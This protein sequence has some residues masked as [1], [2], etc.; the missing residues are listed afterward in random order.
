MGGKGIWEGVWGYGLVWLVPAEGYEGE[1]R[2][3]KGCEKE[4]WLEKD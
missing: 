2:A 4:G 3:W 1:V